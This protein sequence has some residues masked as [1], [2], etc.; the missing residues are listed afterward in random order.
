MLHFNVHFLKYDAVKCWS[1]VFQGNCTYSYVFLCMTSTSFCSQEKVIDPFV[2]Y[3]NYSVL[4]EIV[5]DAVFGKQIEKLVEAT[6]IVSI[7][8]YISDPPLTLFF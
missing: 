5:S 4:R 1:L 8:A 6:N 2:L 3:N 7:H